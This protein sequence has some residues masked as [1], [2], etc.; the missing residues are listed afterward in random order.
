MIFDQ[1]KAQLLSQAIQGKL[2]PHLAEEGTVEQIGDVPEEV[3]FEIPVSW[4]WVTLKSVG[5]IVGGGTPKTNINEYWD[6]GDINWF[7]PADLGTVNS[8]YATDSQRKINSLGLKSSSATLMPAG[9]VLYSSRAPIGHLAI[10]T[11]EC[12]TSQ[13]CKSFVPNLS[14]ISSLWAYYVLMIRTP[15]II[16]RASGSTFKEVNGKEVGKTI[17]PL[18]PLKEQERIV[19]KLEN[20]FEELA[21]AEKA[22]IELQRLSDDFRAAIFQEAIQGKLIP[23]LA[24]DGVVEQLGKEP[25]KVPFEI[26]ESWKWVTFDQVLLLENGDRGKNYP[27]KDKLSEA[28][29][30]YPFVSAINL[31]NGFIDFN[32]MR[33]MSLDQAS[34]IR[35]GHIQKGD[36]LFCIR[37]SLGKFGFS[38]FDGGAIASSLV[39]LRIKNKI[40]HEFL[41]I[42]LNSPL[43]EYQISAQKNGTAQPNL[44][45]NVLSSFLL[46]LPPLKEQDRIV[47][48]V[49]ELLTQVA[50]LKI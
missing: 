2:V 24:D 14:Y 49:D 6:N 17:I 27:S 38:N 8:I 5:K 34:K 28:N 40:S 42:I 30:G 36:C 10:A 41:K 20:S 46:P 43:V 16:S 12:C 29:T 4:K 15:D 9:A 50:S 35:S 18:P 33:F 39:I 45:A 23:Q 7:T 31:R 13:G 3:P 22:Y 32:N 21:K 48:K 44:G 37:G 47:K 11:T 25:E 1:L 19:K 26:P